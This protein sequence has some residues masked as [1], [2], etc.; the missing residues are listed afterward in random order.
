MGE[1][2]FAPMGDR[3]T[4]LDALRGI[5][6]LMVAATHF[7][8]LTLK[9]GYIAGAGLAVDFFFLLSGF[10]MARTY[11]ERMPG[12]G[13]FLAIRARRLWAALA[14]GTLIGATITTIPLYFL[15]LALVFLPIPVGN[16]FAFNPPAWSLFCELVANATHAAFFHST[17]RVVIM[18]AALGPAWALFMAGGASA[19]DTWTNIPE[20]M[21]RVLIAYSAGVLLWR[22]LPTWAVPAWVGP[23]AFLPCLFLPSIYSPLIVLIGFPLAIMSGQRWEAGIIGLWVGRISYPLYAVHFPLMMLPIGWPAVLAA[24]VVGTAAATWVDSLRAKRLRIL[25]DDDDTVR[26]NTSGLGSA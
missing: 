19:A 21:L 7:S 23:A 16:P 3:L 8:A 25:V 6:A 5:A 13:T 22:H 24:V 18:L 26:A 1:L 4:G 10:I 17:R 11:D 9:T 20:A 12:A 2:G 15:P 14:L